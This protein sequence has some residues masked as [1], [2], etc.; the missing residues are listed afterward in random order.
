MPPGSSAIDLG[1]LAREARLRQRP[2]HAGRRADDEE[3]RTRERR[4]IDQGRLEP[5]P[6]DICAIDEQ[7]ATTA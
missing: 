7:A 2:G 3:D 1:E 6:G 5:A 4:R